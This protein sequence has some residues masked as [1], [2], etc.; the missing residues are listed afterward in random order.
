MP[1]GPGK[2]DDITTLAREKTKAA[3]VVVL[4]IGG[5]RGDG[6]DMQIDAARIRSLPGLTKV[7]VDSL[8]DMA[9]TIERDMTCVIGKSSS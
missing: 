3:C 4:I 6:F 7:I 5:E 9:A 8:R 2:Y 1:M